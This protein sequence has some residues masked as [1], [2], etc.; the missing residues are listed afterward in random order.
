MSMPRYTISESHETISSG[1]LAASCIASALLPAAVGPTTASTGGRAGATSG[2][3][4]PTLDLAERQP[5]QHGPAVRTMRAQI[6][7]VQVAQQRQRLGPGQHV[8]GAQDAVTG[9]RGQTV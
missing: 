8:A 1:N 2:A 4:K 9:P 6:H 3:T 5:Q 7:R